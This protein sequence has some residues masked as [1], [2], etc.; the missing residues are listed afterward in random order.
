MVSNS[1]RTSGPMCDGF[2]K[3]QD[4]IAYATSMFNVKISGAEPIVVRTWARGQAIAEN[5]NTFNPLAVAV[6]AAFLRECDGEGVEDFNLGRQW[7]VM[8]HRASQ[9]EFLREWEGKDQ[10]V[11]VAYTVGFCTLARVRPDMIGAELAKSCDAIVELQLKL[12]DQT[13]GGE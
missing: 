9:G 13:T 10:A 2:R 7:G 4:P 1:P 12:L 3:S 11:A 6:A 8:W 5:T